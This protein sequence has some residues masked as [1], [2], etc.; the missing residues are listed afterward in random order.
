[1]YG[2]DGSPFL[3]PTF[4]CDR[5]LV[6]EVYGKYKAWSI[7]FERNRKRQFI[8]FPFVVSNITIRNTFH[9]LEVY[10]MLN[11]FNMKEVQPLQGFDL[12]GLF[13]E[14]LASMR[15]RNIFTRIVEG[16]CNNDQNTPKK[17]GKK[18]VMM[19]WSSKLVRTLKKKASRKIHD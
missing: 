5:Y 11:A 3:L 12:E 10:E 16:T 13:S 18:H 8:S 15:Y 17:R 7:L 2:Y 1:L 19:I 14:H 6:A 9:L 4:V